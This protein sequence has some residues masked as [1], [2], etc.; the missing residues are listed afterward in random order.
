MILLP[1]EI[2]PSSAAQNQC[3]NDPLSSWLCGSSGEYSLD[4]WGLMATFEM[5]A[6]QGITQSLCMLV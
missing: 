2:A 5:G 3:E 4:K 1:Y 6:L